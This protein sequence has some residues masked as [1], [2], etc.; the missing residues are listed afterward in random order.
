MPDRMFCRSCCYE[1]TGLEDPPADPSSPHPCPECGR[2]FRADRPR[3]WQS[4]PRSPLMQFVFGKGGAAVLALVL[5]A[6]CVWQTWLPRPDALDIS[7]PA[8]LRTWSMWRWFGMRFG[9]E[10]ARLNLHPVEVS[11]TAD[12][13]SALRGYEWKTGAT[14]W[15]VE[16]LGQGRARVT[17]LEPGLDH[18]V[19]IP[20][21]EQCQDWPGKPWRFRRASPRHRVSAGPAVL[22]GTWDTLVP[23][24]ARHF[25]VVQT[26]VVTDDQQTDLHVID[27]AEDRV[28]RVSI[29]AARRMGYD[30]RFLTRP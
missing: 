12:K 30:V 16:N 18:R 15:T 10:H 26:P 21:V 20:S 6:I 25:S 24:L 19:V 13:P 28:R 11:Y 4:L 8:V 23:A 5:L 7:R 14:L 2:P 3:T 29:D 1:L 27:P 22:E 17:L 9:S